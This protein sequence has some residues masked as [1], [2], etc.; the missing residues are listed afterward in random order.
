MAAA[1]AAAAAQ[2][3]GCASMSCLDGATVPSTGDQEVLHVRP[4]EPVHVSQAGN[5][6]PQPRP[7]R[8]PV[9][10][11]SEPQRVSHEGRKTVKQEEKREKQKENKFPLF[12]S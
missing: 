5:R 11:H 6:T 3:S 7:P 1:A 8:S 12:L 10:L 2:R 4:H 9:V